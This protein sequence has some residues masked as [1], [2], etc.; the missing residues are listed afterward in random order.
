[1]LT[2]D[3]L[4]SFRSVPNIFRNNLICNLPT[5]FTSLPLGFKTHKLTTAKYFIKIGQTRLGSLLGLDSG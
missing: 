4:F 3:R 5:M 2:I 1:M